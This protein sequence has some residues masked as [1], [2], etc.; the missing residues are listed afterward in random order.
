MRIG[1]G[2]EPQFV[3]KVRVS[4]YL[5]CSKQ[6]VRAGLRCIHPN[7]LHKLRLSL[8]LNRNID[9]RC[10]HGFDRATVKPNIP[11]S[12]GVGESYL[13]SWVLDF[14]Q[15]L[16]WNSSFLGRYEM[17]TGLWDGWNY[18]RLMWWLSKQ[19]STHTL[20]LAQTW[21]PNA[22]FRMQECRTR[23]MPRKP[24]HKRLLGL[25]SPE[26][27]RLTRAKLL[28]ILFP[29]DYLES[30]SLKLLH[31]TSTINTLINIMIQLLLLWLG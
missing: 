17:S 21:R 3:G 19:A 29:Q 6:G 15:I 11:C 1:R 23:R 20:L 22:A 27:S 7:A 14:C 4:I 13:K 10:W 8:S 18:P 2:E 30:K 28:I 16:R 24:I 26:S 12:I 9:W 5:L 25:K 31:L